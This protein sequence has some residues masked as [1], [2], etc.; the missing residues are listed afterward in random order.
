[1]TLKKSTIKK[2]WKLFVAWVAYFD[3]F[4]S[5]LTA[6]MGLRGPSIIFGVSAMF[7]AVGLLCLPEE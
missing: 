1:M 7:M 3:V 2:Y 4:M 6:F 5:M